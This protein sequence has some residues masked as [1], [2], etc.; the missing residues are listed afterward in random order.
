M[1]VFEVSQLTY[2]LWVFAIRAVKNLSCKQV[3][4]TQLGSGFLSIH[5]DLVPTQMCLCVM[6]CHLAL[7]I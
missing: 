1:D 5:S 7:S 6:L 2:S 3:C 4:M